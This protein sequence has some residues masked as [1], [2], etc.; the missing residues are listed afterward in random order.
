MKSVLVVPSVDVCK[1][2]H[3]RWEKSNAI[4]EFDTKTHDFKIGETDRCSACGADFI[5]KSNKYKYCPNC[6]AKMDGEQQCK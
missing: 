6:G 3:G 2:V 4:V 1:V 5:C